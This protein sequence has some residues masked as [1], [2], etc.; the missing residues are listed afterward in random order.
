MSQ[1]PDTMLT[2]KS[3]R[4]S[5][6]R[7]VLSLLGSALLGGLGAGLGF[8]VAAP[9][10]K[11]ALPASGAIL[12]P[13]VLLE[14]IFALATHELGHLLMGW[15]VGFR[16]Q[17]FVLGPLCIE[18][19]ETEALRVRWNRDLALYGGLAAS[20]PTDTRNLTA[21]FA[22]YIAGGPLMS[23][24]LAGLAILPI[25]LFGLPAN[26]IGKLCLGWMGFCC[27]IIFLVTAI[28]MPNGVFLTDGARFLR[29]R[30]KDAFAKR[31]TALLHLFALAGARVRPADWDSETVEA[32][33]LPA[34]GSLFECQ[35]RYLA[36]LYTLDHQDSAQAG[37][38][39]DRVLEILPS[40]PRSMQGFYRLEAAYFEAWWRRRKEEAAQLLAGV[41][42]ASPGI[43]VYERL[44][45]QAALQIVRGEESAAAETLTKALQA[46]PTHAA[47]SRAR[48]TEML[49]SLDAGRL[50]SPTV[51]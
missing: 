11:Q 12:L 9:L 30:R 41:P 48:I 5:V 8:W 20:V 19:D 32:A 13:V 10:L 15:I 36:Y 43:P 7:Q 40:L 23:L 21:R 33:L 50:T 46:V 16:F 26:P 47:W 39:L 45:A 27:G 3:K 14:V 24:L 51:C 25:A 49:A 38:H 42:A 44:R 34:D 6:G 35:A 22:W 4:S 31:D 2:Q 28:P 17:L 37:L 18:R 1:Q 29:L